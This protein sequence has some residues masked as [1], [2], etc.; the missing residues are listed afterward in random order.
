MAEHGYSVRHLVV[1]QVGRFGPACSCGW[2]GPALD[3]EGVAAAKTFGHATGRSPGEIKPKR[4]MAKGPLQVE[5]IFDPTPY[6][7]G[8]RGGRHH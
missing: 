1:G 5:T 4:R 3:D 7:D 6:V 8:N 2:T